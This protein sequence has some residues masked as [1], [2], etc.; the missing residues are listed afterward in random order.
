MAVKQTAIR[1]P[2]FQ[3]V[4]YQ[5]LSGFFVWPRLTLHCVPDEVKQDPLQQWNKASSHAPRVSILYRESNVPLQTNP[6]DQN[7]KEDDE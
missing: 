3:P 6:G 7:R 2:P 1:R 5:Y 4:A